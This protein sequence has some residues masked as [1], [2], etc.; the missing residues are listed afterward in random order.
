L[1]R[2][3]IVLSAVAL[4]AASLSACTPA[5]EEKPTAGADVATPRNPFFGTWEVTRARIAPWLKEGEPEPEADPEFSRFTLQADKSS[6]PQLLTCDDPQYA[7]NMVSARGLFEGNLPD[8]IADAAALG[9]ASQDITVLSFACKSGTADIGLDF[10][11]LDDGQI[12]LGL[13]NVIYT[14][15][16]TGD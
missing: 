4:L 8:P 5:A 16:R 3:S 14:F 15:T 2:S 7:T 9:F 13:S 10:A 12:M 11:M 1:L 6:G